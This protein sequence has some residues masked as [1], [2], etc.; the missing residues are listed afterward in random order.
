M[1]EP[2]SA[3]KHPETEIVEVPDAAMLERAFREF[4]EVSRRLEKKYELLV[5]ETESL[6]AQ[7]REKDLAVKRAER[8][9]TLGETAAAIAH[10]VRN[11]LGAIKLFVGLLRREVAGKKSAG[12]LV[13]QIDK[14]INHLD[15]VVSNI[16]QFSRDRGMELAPVNLNAIIQERVCAFTSGS[17]APHFKVEPKLEA[18]PFLRGNEHGLRQVVYNLLLN[19]AQATR[20][21]GTVKISTR[22]DGPN[23]VLLTVRDDGPGIPAEILGKVF[24]P[25]VTTRNEGTGLG[26]AIVQQI[27]E[28]H[29]GTIAV[30]NDGGA[31]FSIT[32]PRN[33]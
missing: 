8:L 7:L 19:A 27:L 2:T 16:L 6:R 15:G 24:E 14:S 26:L 18:A 31:V 20:H 10:E 21:R 28:H 32:L 4:N 22:D 17:D 30:A 9:A 3:L 5:R 13:E 11:P 23:A 12:E 33:T 1:R 29:G 25:F